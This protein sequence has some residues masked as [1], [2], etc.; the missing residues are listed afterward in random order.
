MAK[1]LI[2]EDDM[3][4]R[5]LVSEFL[6]ILGHEIV[7]AIDGVDGLEKVQN[8]EPELIFC[9]LMMPKLDGYGFLEQHKCSDY[10][11]IPVILMTAMINLDYELINTEFN[12]KGYVRKPF[13]FEELKQVIESNI[14]SV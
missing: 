10:A 9:D 11:H 13:T 12:V 3:E 8:E 1:I 2:I 5:T 6:L 14:F 7:E 4:I